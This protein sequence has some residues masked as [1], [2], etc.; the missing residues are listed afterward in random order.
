MNAISIILIVVAFGCLAFSYF[1]AKEESTKTVLVLAFLVFFI[2]GITMIGTETKESTRPKEVP[3][4]YVEE[5]ELDD[6]DEDVWEEDWQEETPD[7]EDTVQPTIKKRYFTKKELEA[8][9]DGRAHIVNGEVVFDDA[10]K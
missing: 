1:K 3:V 4:K 7:V 5:E 2:W 6:E 8:I 9:R 10:D